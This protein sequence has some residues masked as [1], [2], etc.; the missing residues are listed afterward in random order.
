M[1][2]LKGTSLSVSKFSRTAYVRPYD[3]TY[4][5]AVTHLMDRRA[6]RRSCTVSIP[7]V[8]APAPPNFW[9]DKESKFSVVIKL[10]DI[11]F[12]HDPPWPKIFVKQMLTHNLFAIAVGP[13]PTLF[14]VVFSLRC[15][16]LIFTRIYGYRWRSSS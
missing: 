15:V 5:D 7:R 16:N 11:I 9:Y 10:N 12:L 3:L 13:T 2:H 8:K 14:V 4:S 1:P 6:S